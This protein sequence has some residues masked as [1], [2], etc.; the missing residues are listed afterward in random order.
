MITDNIKNWKS[1]PGVTSHPVW[2]AAFEWIEANAHRSEVGQ[3]DL[4]VGGAFVRVMEYDLKERGDAR[5]E[6]HLATID[7]QYTIEGAEGIEIQSVELLEKEGEFLEEKDFQFYKPIGKG[8]HR[9][10]NT[11]GNFCIL[12]PQDGHMPQ[13]YV[14]GFTHVRKL[15]VKIPVSSVA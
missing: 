11:T 10:D 7:L 8:L 5:Y 12:Y 1:L 13:L 2:K 3:Y 9:V 6:S 4:G 14:N 15:V